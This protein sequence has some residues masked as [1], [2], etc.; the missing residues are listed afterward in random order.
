MNSHIILK[1]VELFN[2][3]VLAAVEIKPLGEV[4]SEISDD[5]LSQ[6]E[7]EAFRKYD[8]YEQDPEDIRDDVIQPGSAGFA[9]VD[10][11]KIL[12]YLYGYDFIYGDN[13]DEF[14]PEENNVKWFSGFD[15]SNLREIKSSAKRNKIFYV[16]NLAISEGY[17]SKFLEMALA[18]KK[19]LKEKGYEY[20]FFNALSDSY[21]LLVGDTGEFRSHV[22]SRFGIQPVLKV[23]EEGVKHLLFKVK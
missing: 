20:I 14:D 22:L 3:A 2:R 8:A 7:Q 19:V 6:L 5:E 10:D 15:E 12:G 9:L 1:S 16:I 17:K 18:L 11:G 21:R 13:W 4:I 23:D